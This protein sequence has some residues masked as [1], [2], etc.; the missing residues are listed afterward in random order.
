[1]PPLLPPTNRLTNRRRP[2]ANDSTATDDAT[3]SAS[4]D[5]PMPAEDDAPASEPTGD[6]TAAVPPKG[7]AVLTPSSLEASGNSQLRL[8]DGGIILSD[9]A[10]RENE[11]YTILV[12][13]PPQAITALRLEA[14]PHESLPG[15]GPGWGLAGRFSLSQFRVLIETADGSQPAR[16]IGFTAV[17]EPKDDLAK[18][19]VDDSD[20]S[21]WTVRRRGETVPVT[22]LPTTPLELPEGSRLNI[23]LVQRENLGCFRLLATSDAD[24]FA[25]AAAPRRLPAAR[26]TID[27]SCLP[28][29]AGMPTRTRRETSG[30]NR[31]STVCGTLDTRA[32]C[33][34][35]RPSSRIRSSCGPRRRSGG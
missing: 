28:I 4:L 7:Y 10:T 22:L 13:T 34:R 9:G 30:R 6:G 3:E 25:A 1:L 35:E 24:P 31:R 18:R 23:T 2:L 8:L 27:S 29:W 19:L 11:Q 15:T 14:L 16:K 26:P 33:R 17:T 5:P 32:G 20:D 12:D 21:A